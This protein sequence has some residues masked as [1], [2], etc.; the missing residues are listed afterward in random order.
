MKR[1]ALPWVG[2]LL[3][4]NLLAG[5]GARAQEETWLDQDFEDFPPG[6]HGV[7]LA[8]GGSP[9]GRWQTFGD[10]GILPAIQGERAL[11]KHAVKVTRTGDSNSA[12]LCLPKPIPIASGKVRWEFKVYVDTPAATQLCL[13]RNNVMFAGVYVTSGP[14]PIQYWDGAAKKWSRGT[15]RI[16]RGTWV[17]IVLTLDLDQKV[18]SA[19]MGEKGRESLF[20]NKALD[21][22]FTSPIEA[23]V[24][25]PQVGGPMYFDDFKI[26]SVP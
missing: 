22:D 18:Y 1:N 20:E 6:F 2:F 19:A 9:T 14:D 11:G 16:P 3:A 7:Y 12:L 24:V 10:D 26:T 15:A 5:A 21:P 23:M 25:S 8:R 4:L 17:R 13:E